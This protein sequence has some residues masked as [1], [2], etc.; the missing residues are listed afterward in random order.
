MGFYIKHLRLLTAVFSLILFCAC[1][2]KGGNQFSDFIDLGETGMSPGRQYIFEPFKVNLKDSLPNDFNVFIEIRYSE[3]CKISGLPLLIEYSSLK[4]DSI[5]NAEILIDL[6]D[7]NSNLPG[8]SA[9]GIYETSY[10]LIEHQ[11]FEESF[12]VS[13]ATPEIDTGGVLSLGVVCRN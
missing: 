4:E 6:F 3:K 5:H 9:Y 11:P 13:I 12:F 10:K 1:R 7:M 8:K 2:Q